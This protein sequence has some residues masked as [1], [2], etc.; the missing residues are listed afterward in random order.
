MSGDKG[1][2][3]EYLKKIYGNPETD[4]DYRRMKSELEPYLDEMLFLT[5][6][7]D[8]KYQGFKEQMAKWREKYSDT[9]LIWETVSSL[10]YADWEKRRWNFS[11]LSH[12]FLYLGVVESI[13]SDVVNF[14]MLLLIACGKDFH[15]ERSHESPRVVHAE[16]MEDLE[17]PEVSLGSKI[18][19][20]ER[21]K[22]EVSSSLID[23]TLRNKIAH[24][25]LTGSI[26]KDGNLNEDFIKRIYEGHN[27]FN[28]ILTSQ[29][30]SLITSYGKSSRYQAQAPTKRND[31]GRA[32]SKTL[33]AQEE[34]VFRNQVA[35]PL[36]FEPKTY[37]LGGCRA[38][39]ISPFSGIHIEG[40]R[41][42]P[43]FLEKGGAAIIR[44]IS[45]IL[46]SFR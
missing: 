31:S 37:S 23:R 41:H 34:L 20:L 26:D 3:E 17:S 14:M 4:K 25:D 19:F 15:V 8:A 38:I 40:L 13:G 27:R 12:M 30:Y 7:M 21:N 43:S 6:K 2:I 16:T 29:K 32:R 39:Q 10:E 9:L 24:L 36:G 44:L 11:P 35:G 46:R 45:W 18:T 33:Q 22:L 42:G 28:K 5:G 1:L